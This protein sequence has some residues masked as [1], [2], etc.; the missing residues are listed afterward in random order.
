METITLANNT[1]V[2]VNRSTGC[3][4]VVSPQKGLDGDFLN[5]E[6]FTRVNQVAN[7]AINFSPGEL[8]TVDL[9][10]YFKTTNFIRVGDDG[11]EL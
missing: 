6:E 7:V 4:V 3:L 2:Y 9:K 1:Q 11:K 10:L 5:S 8:V